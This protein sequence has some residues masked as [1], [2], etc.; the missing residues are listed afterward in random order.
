[1]SQNISDNVRIFP[2]AV[3]TLSEYFFLSITSNVG[4]PAL[5]TLKPQKIPLLHMNLGIERHV[6]YLYWWIY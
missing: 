1:M 2:R 4:D 3:P 5:D 6:L